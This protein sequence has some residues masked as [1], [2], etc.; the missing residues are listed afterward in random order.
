VVVALADPPSL[1]VVPV[2]LAEGLTVPEMLN[3]VVDPVEAAKFTSVRLTPLTVVGE[4]DG[5]KVKPFLVGVIVYEPLA[6]LVKV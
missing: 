6:R 2:P 1:T 3:V 4:L 5:L